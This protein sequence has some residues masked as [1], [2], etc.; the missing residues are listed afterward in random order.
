MLVF[1]VEDCRGTFWF[2]FPL[3]YYSGRILFGALL[4]K[5]K[6]GSEGLDLA[7]GASRCLL[8]LKCIAR[9]LPSMNCSLIRDEY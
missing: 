5:P 7:R 6:L 9:K 8:Y 1:K 3:K 2:Y 4:I